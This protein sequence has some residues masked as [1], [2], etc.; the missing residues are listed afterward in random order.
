VSKVR[1]GDPENVEAQAAAFQWINP[2]A[3]T[4]ALTATS[5]YLPDPSLAGVVIVALVFVAINLPS[6]SVWALLGQQL[7]RLLTRH[8]HLRIFNATMAL[9]ILGSLFVVL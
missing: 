5:V 3:W 6:V 8:S 4:M 2:K 1:S 7:A 9:L